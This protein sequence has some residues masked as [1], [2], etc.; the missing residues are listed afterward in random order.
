MR[1]LHVVMSLNSR[2]VL[3]SKDGELDFFGDA[4]E[5]GIH[6]YCEAAVPKFL[7]SCK[8]ESFRQT[9]KKLFEIPFNSS[10]KWQMSIHRIVDEYSSMARCSKELLLFKGAP[11]VLISKCSQF[12]DHEG[13]IVPMTDEFLTDYSAVYEEFGGAGERVL[14]F[15]V[16]FLNSTIEEEL[17]SDSQYLENLKSSYVSTNDERRRDL[18][19]VGLATLMDPP[20]EEVPQAIADCQ[21]AGIQV[22]M[23]TGDHPITAEAIARSIGLLHHPTKS[24]IARDL[25][26]SENDVDEDSVKAAVIH[27]NQISNLTEE[28]WK[29]LVSKP[30]IVFARTSPEQKLLIVQKFTE[31]GNVVAMTG[32]GVNDSPALKQAAVGIAMGVNGS[33]VAREAADVVLLDDNFA[34]IVVG[35]REGRLLFSNLKKSITYTLSHLLPEVLPVLLWAFIGFP[36]TINSIQILCIDLWT[37]L[38]PAS[39]LAFEKAEQNIMKVPPRCPHTDKLVN[40]SVM[41]HSY[42]FLGVVEVGICYFV[43]YLILKQYGLEFKDFA[44]SENEYF[45]GDVDEDYVSYDGKVFSPNEQKR[46]LRTVQAS[47]YLTIVICQ[48]VNIWCCKSRVGSIFTRDI[49]SNRFVNWG[50]LIALSL[51]IIVV[52]VPG[53][54]YVSDSENPPSMIMLYGALLAGAVIIGL[55][56]MQKLFC[57]L[58]PEALKFGF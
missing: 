1:L 15:A 52:Y 23:V 41:L 29:A 20:R 51:G 50:V 16:R 7:C 45:T 46:I 35:V 26:I 57:R 21:A 4:T 25:N 3:E 56:E 18:V 9:N 13:S 34:S 30:E 28:Y 49:F 22:V 44:R 42:A 32:D 14:A 36:Q 53:F 54:Q 43:F 31:A 37:E 47:W 40:S 19:F 33:D 2:V 39:S 10:N 17:Q 11:D 5:L 12:I 48:A 38:A 58:F 55:T 8:L 6:R 27:G 24:T